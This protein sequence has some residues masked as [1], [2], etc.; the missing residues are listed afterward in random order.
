M[1]VRFWNDP[2]DER[3]I[4]A[5]FSTYPGVWRHGDWIRITTRGSAVIYGR[6]DSTINR[7]GIRI[8]TAEV[9]G[10]VLSLE[11][12][13][14]ALAVDV[15]SEDGTGDGHLFLFV[16]LAPGDELDDD[17]VVAL[18]QRIRRDCSPRHVPDEV[19]VVPD[20]PK[21]LTG[22]LLEVP[23]KRLLMGRAVRDAASRD[24]LAN[25]DALD[26]FVRFASRRRQAAEA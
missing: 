25:P 1:P 14:E 4:D 17:L 16:V 20:V 15:P 26:W 22:K 2:G 19:V 21:T 11:R 3:Y 23:V 7:G 10:A 8:G 13:T 24:A 18:R 5:Y 12:V 9:Y 6:S